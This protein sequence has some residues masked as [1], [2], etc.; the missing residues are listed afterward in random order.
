MT[1]KEWQEYITNWAKSKGFNWRKKDINTMLLRLH[2][3]VSEAGEAVRDH[4]KI[5]LA[6]ELADVF[7]RLVNICEVMKI[8][9]E[10]EVKIKMQINETRPFLHNRN[11]K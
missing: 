9:L 8:D 1:I 6:E 2:S 4:N 3:E 7:I 10:L 5:N 11:E